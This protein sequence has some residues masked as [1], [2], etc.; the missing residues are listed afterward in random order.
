MPPASGLHSNP[1]R[2]PHLHTT[3]ICCKTHYAELAFDKPIREGMAALMLVYSNSKTHACM[4]PQQAMA[5]YPCLAS[6]PSRTALWA[7]QRPSQGPRHTVRGCCQ[8]SGG[9]HP[10]AACSG[11][12]VL[13]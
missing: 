7:P 13:L 9:R 2:D 11:G 4:H 6:S 3:S 10:P 1:G 5:L 12:H 8:A